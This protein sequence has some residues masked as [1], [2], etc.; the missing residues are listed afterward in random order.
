[1]PQDN[2]F[3]SKRRESLFCVRVSS[4][5]ARG[6]CTY[7]FED[8]EGHIW[9]SGYDT[10]GYFD[11]ER[12]HSLSAAYA[13]CY[14]CVPM[15]SCWGIAQDQQGALWIAANRLV[16]YREGHFHLLSEADGFPGPYQ[17]NI[18]VAGDGVGGLWIGKGAQIW[19][20]D[21]RRHLW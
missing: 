5:S 9:F 13:R 10:L 19:R 12:T 20:Y 6:T 11:G 14:G 17:G 4:E 7:L 16:R 3:S 21:D 18:A 1:M 15:V 2:P 8:R